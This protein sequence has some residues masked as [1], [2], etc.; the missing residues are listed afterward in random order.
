[1][2][3]L[4]QG[5]MTGE[6][7]LLN[8]TE[9]DNTSDFLP[10]FE[11]RSGSKLSQE[12][13]VYV[14]YINGVRNDKATYKD[15]VNFINNFLKKAGVNS[16]IVD[17]TYNPDGRTKG[18]G[19]LIE[20]VQQACDLRTP[21]KSVINNAVDAI[22]AKE[23][24]EWRKAQESLGDIPKPK[25][26]I[27]G[28]SQGNFFAENVVDTLQK[29][30]PGIAQRT[31][32]LAIS[33]F[34]D[35]ENRT[36][37]NFELN[38]GSG[39]FSKDTVIYD[40]LVRKDDFPNR[41]KN[42][43]CIEI[44]NNKYN[45]PS[46]PGFKKGSGPFDSH[47]I[48]NYL[49]DPDDNTDGYQTINRNKKA[50]RKSF[51]AAKTKVNQLLNAEVAKVKW[52]SKTDS[53]WNDPK[54]WQGGVVP[55]PDDDVAIDIPRANPVIT[56]PNDVTVKSISSEEN[57]VVKGS[58]TVTVDESKIN[59]NLTVSPGASLTVKNFGT[60]LLATGT[61]VINKANL[62]AEN[63]GLLSLPTVSSYT[64]G[65][66][67]SYIQAKGKDS[68][69]QLPA[70]TTLTGSG[71]SSYPVYARA[72]DGG[73][74]DLGAKV[75]KTA[76]TKSV[77]FEADGVGSKVKADKLKSANGYVDLFASNQGILKFPKL[78]TYKGA[79]YDSYIQ[80]KDKGSKIELPSLNTLTGSRDS[81][82]PVYAR[83]LDGATVSLGA[84]AVDGYVGMFATNGGTLK[85]PKLST[86][87]GA[88]YDSYIQA[89]GKG[90]KVELPALTTLTGSG[91]SDY[92]VYARA[93]DGATVDL[94]AKAGKTAVTKSV[95]FE[96]DGVGS[97]VKAD[98]LVSANGYVD[99][100][101][102][103]QGTLKFPKLSTYNGAAYDSYIQAKDKGSK[104]ELPAL[105]KLTGSRDSSYPVYAR[106]LDGATVD[107]RNLTN[108]PSGAF[109]VAADGKGSSV[110][111]SA[112]P[113]KR[114]PSIIKTNGGKVQK[115]S[116]NKT[117]EGR[118]KDNLLKEASKDDLING[119]A[120]DD[121]LIGSN[122]KD[123]LYGVNG[124]D[125][126]DGDAGNDT[127]TGGQGADKF[128]FKT[129]RKFKKDDL[130]VDTIA[131]FQHNID[132]IILDK[133]TFVSLNSK[134]GNGFSRQGEFAVVKNDN[135]AAKSQ[136]E[137]VYNSTNGKL[138]YNPN[139]AANGFGG[140]GLFAELTDEP[141]LT[142]SDFMLQ[143]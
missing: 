126:L 92:P 38:D 119:Q 78:N 55:G 23:K 20:S 1:M 3:K 142:R 74:V 26:L 105:T 81:S 100:F 128:L 57:I 127:L 9:E 59:G 97:T 32:I 120:G 112:L 48:K 44:P 67:D 111:I 125:I 118:S 41:L 69:I 40:Y 134:A 133:T 6:T 83:A 56:I 18:L 104:I 7:L 5:E 136:A 47:D 79:A 4:L 107:V 129:K 87:K 77:Q 110:K 58:L 22:L 35:F 91:D 76:V 29:D 15:S 11:T 27:F 121:T 123:V 45:L 19:D 21:G 53:N 17:T 10:N 39:E 75:G 34:T 37:T 54:N 82:Y 25:F 63:G 94:G 113:I 114:K 65:A 108:I 60:Y 102:S 43:P 72:L 137:I 95:Q 14:F 64:G 99:L 85:F 50:V 88:A 86:Y 109:T 68:K 52:I 42:L 135:A 49:D 89:E 36:D 80:A 62:F 90:S 131:D 140:G 132:D 61:T 141:T 101:A 143:N 130:G 12:A 8:P 124:D 103:N 16:Q 30:Y 139:G 93:R 46:L 24:V 28:H 98:K 106:A 115:V 66:Y 13:P 117:I 122:G 73:T 31:R 33:T 116:S 96:A 84:K 2:S 138:F 70:L 51:E 71:D